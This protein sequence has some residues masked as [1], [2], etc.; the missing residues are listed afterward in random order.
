MLVVPETLGG[1]DSEGRGARPRGPTAKCGEAA[2]AVGFLGKTGGED[3]GNE[4]AWGSCPQKL[5]LGN[6][7][8]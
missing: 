4:E 2:E 8:P 6:E 1:A 3:S 7:P 5:L